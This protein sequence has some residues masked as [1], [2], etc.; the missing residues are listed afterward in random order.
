MKFNKVVLIGMRGCGKSHF[1]SC[2]AKE[3]HWKKIDTDDEIVKK[4]GKEISEIVS[5]YGWETFRNLEHDI[6]KEV[7]TQKNVIISTGGGAITFERNQKVLQKDALIVFLFVPFHKLCKRLQKR[8]SQ[9]KRP[10]LKN[11]LSIPDE[12]KQ[13]WE[14]R[15]DIYF[16]TADI[17]FKAKDDLSQNA[18]INVEKNAKI[19]A[20][21]IKSLLL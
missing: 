13:V 18:K 8:A 4:S 3:L 21:K 5:L 14:E 6:C 20:K 15:A 19:L 11:K 10:A 12:I 17:V 7:S 9:K 16:N 2:L 1:A